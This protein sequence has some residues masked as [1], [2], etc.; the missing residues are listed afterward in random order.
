MD[1]ARFGDF[2]NQSYVS[3]RA[4]EF[5]EQRFGFGAPNDPPVS[6][7]PLKTTPLYSQHQQAGA[8]FAGVHAV[9]T[10]MVFASRDFEEKPAFG[11][12]NA[13]DHI[14]K[15]CL[16]TRDSAGVLDISG[17]A[18]YLVS[19]PD[20]EAFL[21]RVLACRLPK[22]GRTRLAP[23]LSAS[24]RL[25]GDLLVAQ[26]EPGQFM[27]TGSGSMQDIHMRWF[28]AQRGNF[29]ISLENA[30]DTL[31]GI[32]ISGPDATSMLQ[33]IADCDVGAIP[34]MGCTPC[35]AAMAP[36]RILRVSLT[37]ERG[38]EVYCPPHYMNSLYAALLSQTCAA[39]AR[40]I[41]IYALLSLRIE[42][43]HG[44]WT[45]EFAQDY[46]PEMAQL[47]PFVDLQKE[48]F[49]GHA[50]ITGRRDSTAPRTLSQFIVQ[51]DDVDALGHEPIRLNGRLVG[52]TTSGA[53]GHRIEASVAMGYLDSEI[54]ETEGFTIDIL[55]TGYA[56][57]RSTEPAYD[58][59]GARLR[60]E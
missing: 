60:I 37:G 1:V 52:F 8:I 30:T 38:Y 42:K 14:R 48:G 58:P 26:F 43:G 24:G 50:A 11:R 35:V 28:E 36:A 12:S 51:T 41:G 47:M 59:A 22:P 19:G 20:A 44:I 7:R 21:D 56:A 27:L 34:F 45:R 18:K 31:A 55:G 16:A 39:N 40:P 32:A 53:Y 33:G 25:L 9:E 13:F 17:Y 15:E 57:R 4:R 29:E 23:I 46:T 3:R 54:E 6:A 2:A 49:I 10:P 5:Y